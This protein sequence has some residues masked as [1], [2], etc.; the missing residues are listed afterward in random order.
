MKVSGRAPRLLA[1]GVL[2]LFTIRCGPGVH[3][4]TGCATV[5]RCKTYA[6]LVLDDAPL[7]YYRLNESAAG[8]SVSD[9]SGNSQ[10]ATVISVAPTLSTDIPFTGAGKSYYFSGTEA[11]GR[12]P[13]GSLNTTAGQRITVEAWLKWQPSAV[14]G[15]I[16]WAIGGTSSPI[17]PNLL[18]NFAHLPTDTIGLASGS[19]ELWGM[20][21]AGLT[22]IYQNRWMHVVWDMLLGPESSTKIYFDGVLQSSSLFLAAEQTLQ[23]GSGRVFEVGRNLGAANYWVGFLDEIAIYNGALS[24]ERVRLHYETAA[25]RACS[26]TPQ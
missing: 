9:S 17:P 12:T 24:A 11:F 16:A 19:G 5:Y 23:V 21:D 4:A 20:Q 3:T 18:G 22:G 10:T 7:A 8:S 13:L 25:G 6:E 1:L 2:S 14:N 26:L 15:Y